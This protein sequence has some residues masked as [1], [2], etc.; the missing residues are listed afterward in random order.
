MPAL[1]GI[2]VVDL[3]RVVAGPYC[4][5]QLA[6]MGA[7]VTKI[8]RPG[9]GDPVRRSGAGSGQRFRKQ[10]MASN[11]LSQNANKRALTPNLKH[12]EGRAVF[13]KLV[14]TA[15]VVVE[16][17]R[18]GVMDK[19]GIGYGTLRAKYPRLIFCSLTGYGQTGPKAQHTAYDGVIQAASGMMSVIGTPQTGPLKV[20]PPITDRKRHV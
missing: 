6:L 13:M 7:Q 12:D 2:K 8:E 11:F 4:T 5:Y 16:N 17:F 15:D 10:A 3:T 9:Q 18:S 1:N 14:D 20:G 19:L